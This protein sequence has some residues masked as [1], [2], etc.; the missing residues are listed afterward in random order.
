MFSHNLYS[1]VFT[2]STEIMK[3]TH[4]YIYI[5]KF[6]TA[7]IHLFKLNI[8]TNPP[9]STLASICYFFILNT[10]F[11]LNRTAEKWSDKHLILQVAKWE[12]SYPASRDDANSK[13]RGKVECP[14]WVMMLVQTMVSAVWNIDWVIFTKLILRSNSMVLTST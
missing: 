3:V 11:K 10:I 14:M 9:L 1:L 2:A 4:M 6:K 7:F 13:A 5:F 8:P 12:Q